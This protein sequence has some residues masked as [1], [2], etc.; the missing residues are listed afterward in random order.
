MDLTRENPDPNATPQ[1]RAT[2]KSNELHDGLGRGQGGG[3]GGRGRGRAG[4]APRA[5]ATCRPC[6]ERPRSSSPSRTRPR[7]GRPGGDL[8]RYFRGVPRRTGAGASRVPLAASA[9]GPPVQ[10]SPLSAQAS[11]S[12]RPPLPLVEASL[13]SRRGSATG[14]RLGGPGSSLPLPQLTR[15]PAPSQGGCWLAW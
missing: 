1:P 14:R 7:R 4:L 15:R 2:A 5:A 12:S 6:C 3:R 8:C 13:A 10:P 11:A 9:T